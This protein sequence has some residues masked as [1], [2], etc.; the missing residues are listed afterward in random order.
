MTA[1]KMDDSHQGMLCGVIYIANARADLVTRDYDYRAA[2]YRAVN[3][4]L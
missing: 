3:A 4:M 2:F 1:I